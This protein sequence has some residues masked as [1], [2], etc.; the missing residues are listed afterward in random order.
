MIKSD[1]FEMPVVM[2]TGLG[3]P[4][5]IASAMEACMFLA[6]WLVSRRTRPMASH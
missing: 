1:V 3:H 4:A 6:D 2:L 5:A